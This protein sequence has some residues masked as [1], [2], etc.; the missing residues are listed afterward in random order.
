MK[1]ISSKFKSI[2]KIITGKTPA[3]SNTL[4]F[5]GEI[6]FITPADLHGSEISETS[7]YLT[8]AGAL[9]VNELPVGA[10]LVSCI[11]SL[12]KVGITTK[13]A[14]TNQQINALVFDEDIVFPKYAFHY[15]KTLKHTL[16]AIAPS[17]TIPIVN[18]SR[19]SEL[20][21][22]LPP[23]SEQ[24]RIAA[25]LDK[26]EALSSKRREAITKLDQLLQSVFFEMFGDPVT[27]PK[28]WPRKKLGDYLNSI[29]SGKSP[30][31]L[32]RPAMDNEWGV[33][34]LGAVTQCEFIETQSKALPEN[35][36]PDFRNEVKPGDLLFSRKN[37][38]ELVAACA[39]V[40]NTRTK[41]LLPDLIFR[42][43]LKPEALLAKEYLHSLLIN[44]GKRF[45]IQSL[46]GG[47]AGSMPNISK[48]KLLDVLIEVPSFELQ[49]S[50][51]AFRN[52]IEKIKSNTALMLERHEHLVGSLQAQFFTH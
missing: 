9:Q 39:L 41:L 45:E 10:V 49:Q 33:L 16:E 19:F 50:Y 28:N 30:V 38:R 44:P 36:S 22:P 52:K 24:R 6:P 34:K 51:A 37:T 42:L 13:R 2:A 26:A 17:T 35:I 48:A 4:F 8:E 25:I 18:K 47:A 14:C 5:G 40:K 20:D 12:G 29:D 1:I 11:G 7:T 21:F 3:T 31:C 27:N 15:C 23:L 46:A 43:T 32:D